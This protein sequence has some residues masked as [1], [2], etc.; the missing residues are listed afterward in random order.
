MRRADERACERAVKNMS[1]E[2]RA[3]LIRQKA[4][5]T[6]EILRE[7]GVD[8]WLIFVRESEAM[9]DASLDTVVGSNV[10]WQSA[11]LFTA[12]GERVAIVG[13]LDVAR[14]ERAGVFPEIIGYKG[15]IREDLRRVMTR[16]DPRVLALNYSTENELADGLSHGM[17][18]LLENLLEGM[19]ILA[20][21][22]SSE[23]ILSALP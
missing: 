19:G 23:R 22:V 10:T 17:Y 20:R 12:A 6:P 21:A 15:G 3:D 2:P 9:H 11:F 7:M 14:V 1:M 4:A 16:L 18:L 5:Q 13:S 8:A